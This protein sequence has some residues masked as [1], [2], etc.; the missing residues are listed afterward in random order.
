MQTCLSV[1]FIQIILIF[2]WLLPDSDTKKTQDFLAA[3]FTQ[4]T[5]KALNVYSCWT[6]GLRDV[7]IHVDDVI[8]E[9]KFTT[10]SNV[11]PFSPNGVRLSRVSRKNHHWTKAGCKIPL[12]THKETET[13]TNGGRLVKRQRITK[14]LS[15]QPWINLV[16]QDFI[17]L[18]SS[19]FIP[20]KMLRLLHTNFIQ[21]DCFLLH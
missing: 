7:C 2:L 3:G 16:S 19:E 4:V 18:S 10:M 11:K 8:W 17:S 9:D 20:S 15:S 21:T 6:A 14:P 5:N 12:K 13:A 1:L